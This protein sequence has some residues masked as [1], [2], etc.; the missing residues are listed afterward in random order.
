MWH[1]G[2]ERKSFVTDYVID[3]LEVKFRGLGFFGFRIEH[4]VAEFGLVSLLQREIPT[5][6]NNFHLLKRV[7]VG[8]RD[9]DTNRLAD[10]DVL[11]GESVVKREMTAFLR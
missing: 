7:G 11:H 3:D 10:G 8:L 1:A 9:P 2:A 5:R 4:L 6:R